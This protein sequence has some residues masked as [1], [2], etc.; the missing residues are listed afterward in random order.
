MPDFV[1]N[2]SPFQY[3]HW[4]GQL[5]LLPALTKQVLV[6]PAVVAELAAGRALGLDLPDPAALGWVTVRRAVST[7]VSPVEGEVTC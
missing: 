4:L 6:P 5:D 2:T 7:P 1:C 3:L